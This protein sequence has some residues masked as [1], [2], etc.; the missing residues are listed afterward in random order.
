MLTGGSIGL[1]DDECLELPPY[2]KTRFSPASTPKRARVAINDPHDPAER[3]PKR[4]RMTSFPPT[5]FLP[6]PSQ[7]DLPSIPEMAES[8]DMFN[9]S[10]QTLL[11]RSTPFSLPGLMPT[12]HSSPSL[13]PSNSSSESPAHVP[14]PRVTRV[15]HAGAAY[16]SEHPFF[17]VWELVKVVEEM[18][19]GKP[20]KERLKLPDVIE[21]GL[22]KVVERGMPKVKCCKASYTAMVRTLHHAD[23]QLREEFLSLGDHPDALYRIFKARVGDS[24]TQTPFPW[25]AERATSEDSSLTFPTPTA[26]APSTA[27]PTSEPSSSSPA[28]APDLVRDFFDES[29]PSSEPGFSSPFSPAGDSSLSSHPSPPLPS[30]MTDVP[31]HTNSLNPP[32]QHH[33]DDFVDPLSVDTPLDF[34]SHSYYNDLFTVAEIGLTPPEPAFDPISEDPDF[35]YL[36]YTT[37]PDHSLPDIPHDPLTPGTLDALSTLL[38]NQ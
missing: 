30:S 17:E 12:S 21:L 3:S 26:P 16:P 28:S 4:S 36:F 1:E 15:R 22:I 9:A 5:S 27:V 13:T 24:T 14:Q 34:S 38:D 33:F 31:L 19:L 20:A 2:A 6:L 37:Y 10:G 32:V 29:M 7:S 11:L 25:E 35:T 18:Q 8:D 23:T